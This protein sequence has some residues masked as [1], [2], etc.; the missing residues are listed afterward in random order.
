[1]HIPYKLKVPSVYMMSDTFL[2]LDQLCGGALLKDPEGKMLK[3]H[4]ACQE[5][6]KLSKAIGYLRYLFRSTSKGK[7]PVVTQLKSLLERSPSSMKRRGE[8]SPTSAFS[9]DDSG[10]TEAELEISQQLQAELSTLNIDLNE[11]LGALSD[12]SGDEFCKDL[13]SEL[14]EGDEFCED[15][16]SELNEALG[17]LGNDF[18][19]DLTSGLN[20]ALGELSDDFGED[21]TSGLNEASGELGDDFGEALMDE[22]DETLASMP[23]CARDVAA[24]LTST[25]PSAIDQKRVAALKK[26]AKAPN[27]KAKGKAK[28]KAV[29]TAGFKRNHSSMPENYHDYD[30]LD[31]P[32]EARPCMDKKVKGKYSYTVADPGSCSRIQ[33]LLRSRQFYVTKVAKDSCITQ[34]IHLCSWAHLCQKRAQTKSEHRHRHRH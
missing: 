19:E 34:C 21:L 33:V 16:T 28:G 12:E 32:L 20:E 2:K 13:T 5:G 9:S 25:L 6:A 26:K 27:A 17:E 24:A 18:G 11:A 29:K 10:T 7:S 23:E 22:E 4:M 3:E 31:I 1:M 30:S 15:L 14:N 8:G